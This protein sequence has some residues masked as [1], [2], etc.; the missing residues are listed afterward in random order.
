[1]PKISSKLLDHGVR[2]QRPPF[3]VDEADAVDA[4]VEQGAVDID[5]PLQCSASAVNLRAGVTIV[6]AT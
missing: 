1:M 2:E 6:R 4:G 5:A 3:E